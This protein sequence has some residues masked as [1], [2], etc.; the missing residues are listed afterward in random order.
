MKYD[1][2]AFPGGISQVVLQ[3]KNAERISE[4]NLGISRIQARVPC[5]SLETADK[6]LKKALGAVAGYAGKGGLIGK[7]ISDLD[8]VNTAMHADKMHHS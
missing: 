2:Q 7:L 6:D 8:S 1:K 3:M 4:W 5:T